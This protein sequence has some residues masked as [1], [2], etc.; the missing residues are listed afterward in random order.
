MNITVKT[1]MFT[2]MDMT[3][4]FLPGNDIMSQF[5][6]DRNIIGQEVLMEIYQ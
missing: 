5:C 6:N 1:K 3:E 4:H 2:A